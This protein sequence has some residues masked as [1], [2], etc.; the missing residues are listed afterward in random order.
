MH[1]KSTNYG[2]FKEDC[3]YRLQAEI[4]SLWSSADAVL[5]LSDGKYALIEFK[6]GSDEIEKG[7][8]HLLEIKH[9]VKVYNEKSAVSFLREPDLLIIITGGQMAYT[10]PDGVKI[11]P[12][13][14]LKD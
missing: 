10:R 12:L 6:L 3:R 7:A 13:G 8:K 14:C 11:I 5:H 4:R 1:S 9:L 2:I